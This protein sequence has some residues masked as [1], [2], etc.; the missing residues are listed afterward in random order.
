[1]KTFK[2]LLP[3]LAALMALSA[4]A[5]NPKRE[6]RGAWMHIIG[7][8]QY[9][10][11]TPAET[12]TYLVEQLDLLQKAGCN[13]IIWQ[14]R[15]QAD[16]AYVSDLEPWS[17]WLTGEPGKAPNPV[18]DP[19]EFMINES[20]KRGM[21]LHAWINPYR[22]TSGKDDKPAEGH[23]YYK[24]PEW[25]IKYN[26]GKLYFDP[27]L[28]ES[29]AFI[30]KVVADIVTRYDVDAIHM[31]D[32]FYPYPT[33]MDFP[34]DASYSKYGA[35][36]DRGDWR[37]NNVDLLIEQLHHTIK[38]IK[39]WV[40]LGISPFGIWRNKKDDVNGSE[41]NGLS[42]YDK[43]YADCP[44]W[45]AMGWVDYMVPQLYWELEHPRANDLVLS[46]WWNNH[47][48]GRHMYYGQSVSNV[49]DHRDIAEEKGDTLNPTQLD[50]RTRINRELP[51]VQG[52][53]WWPAY[54]ITKNYKGVMDSLAT[55]HQS[56]PALIQPYKW[57]DDVAPAPVQ[58]LTITK[59]K[60]EVTI[61]WQAPAATDPMQQAARY[62]VYRYKQGEQLDIEDSA[63]IY[64]ITGTTS[65]TIPVDKKD[66]TKWAWAVTAVDRCNN[67]STP[68]LV[69]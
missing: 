61:Q 64:A 41:T 44:R 43:L 49:M 48:N 28:P 33:D 69:Q 34:D 40:Q 10:K 13:A 5:G 35:G 20:H 8:G 9:A 26:D 24:H 4:F 62:V 38:D 52:P 2:F 42:C 14:I 68:A 12:Q 7:Q 47:A 56:T 36:W 27:G 57:L 55:T 22:V 65:V 51:N 16:A 11:M 3:M 6:F 45:T 15:P 23:I 1:M 29:R 32:Y 53:C 58:D 31:D 30:N 46:H 25:F 67:E 66:K 19:L 21:E 17:R 18:W 63:F 50:H 39:P 59:D 54:S 37:R 60:K